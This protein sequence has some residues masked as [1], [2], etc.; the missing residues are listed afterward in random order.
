[1]EAHSKRTKGGCLEWLLGMDV[2]GYGKVRYGGKTRRV[3]RLGLELIGVEVPDRAEVRHLCNNRIC[4]EPSHLMVGNRHQNVADRLGFSSKLTADAIREIRTSHLAGRQLAALFEVAPSTISMIRSRKIW[5]F[6]PDR[7]SE[8]TSPRAM[9]TNTG[10]K[11][12]A[13]TIDR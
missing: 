1:M 3:H 5:G 6:I 13:I 7:V 12:G 4:W 2:G 8:A 11:E 9:E 10:T